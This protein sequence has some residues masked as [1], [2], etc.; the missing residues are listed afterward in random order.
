M[1]VA[2][3]GSSGLI[4]SALCPALAAAGHRAIRVV[5]SDDGGLDTLS[6]DP[7]AG[8]IDAEGLE[9][10]DG[11]VHLAGEG[12][13]KRWS[14]KQKA[15]ILDSRVTGTRLLAETLAKLSRPPG[16]LVSAS[17]VGI[18]GDRGDE[19][20]TEASSPGGGFLA[21]VARAWEEATAA[22]QGAGIRVA[23]LRTGLVL[24]RHGGALP[25]ML[26][27][28]RLGLG[29][30][31]GSG[32]HWMSWISIDD[33]VA[34]ILH[35]LGDERLAGP[36]NAT[37]PNPV[38]NAEFTKALGGALHRPAVLPAPAPA[39]RLLLGKE[40]A[41]EMLLVSQRVVP[42]RLIDSGFQFATP[43]LAPALARVLSA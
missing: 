27:P 14:A 35:L 8:T 38:T 22:A 42:H 41:D 21:S 12:I 16:V 4:G 33:Q 30:R 11:V 13:G 29:G 1:D 26:T 18:Y 32:R 39:L 43:E 24:S 3:T 7:E 31:M 28:F 2:V 5:R 10:V 6:W 36:V 37:A 20:L 19:V 17:A 9:G 23:H 25:K 40:M 15:R 34:A